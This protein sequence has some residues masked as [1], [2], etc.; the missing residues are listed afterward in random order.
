MSNH[1]GPLNP[2]AEWERAARG[3]IDGQ[4]FPW[5][6]TISW[7]RANYYATPSFVLGAGVT[8]D[9]NPT[10]G[11][12][13]TLNDGVT[14]YTSP[15]GTFAP[16]AYG[17]NDMAGNV[18]QWCWDWY[19]DYTSAAQTDPHGPTSGTQH[20]Y[21]GGGWNSQA[22]FCRVAVRYSNPPESVANSVGFRCVSV[23]Q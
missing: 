16:N 18:W 6:N 9:V 22:T 12:N 15:G 20:V 19:G 21:R 4:R 14:P 8:Y 3:G 17:L 10:E 5:G 1:V 13:P 2:E 11:Y 7:V 23:G